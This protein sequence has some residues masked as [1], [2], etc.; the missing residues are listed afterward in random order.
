MVLFD[1][2]SQIESGVCNMV[3]EKKRLP[4]DSPCVVAAEPVGL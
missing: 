1:V 4:Y 3:Q 2:V